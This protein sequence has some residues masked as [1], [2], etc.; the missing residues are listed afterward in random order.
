[1]RPTLLTLAITA[2]TAMPAMAADA[3]DL[4][5]YRSDDA[6]L[7]TS[8][9]YGPSGA[10]YALVHERRRVRLAGGAETLD[11][12]ALPA[13]LDTEAL[14]VR[15][16]SGNVLSRRL[17]L[18]GNAGI[19]DSRIGD[20]VKVLGASGTVL[21]EGTLRAT[22]NG[23]LI[24][25]G[26]GVTLVRDYAAVQ[27]ADANT[28]GGARLQVAV[29]GARAGE[30]DV[31]LDYATGGIG[32][33]AA[34][35]ATLDGGKSCR[36]DFRSLAS[37]ANRSGRD[38][39]ADT[40]KLVAG[41]PDFA[42]NS[43]PQPMMYAVRAE[44]AAAPADLP[45]QAALDDYRSYTIRGAVDLPGASVTQVPLYEPRTLDCT[46]TWLYETGSAWTPPRPMLTRDFNRGGAR[47]ASRLA[48]KAFDSLPAG[49]LRVLGIADDNAELL[50]EAR[51][52]DTPKGRTVDVELGTPF[53]L[54]AEREQTGFSVDKAARTLD[55]GFRI[56]LDNAGDTA[57]TVTVR[58]HPAR[59][60]EWTLLS[61]S[62]KPATQGVDTLEFA[63]NVP[64]HGNATLEYALR[65]QWTPGDEG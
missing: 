18:P 30:Q 22:G 49:Y 46:R 27:L 51:I 31:R 6:S 37:I 8:N 65:Y 3:I 52:A 13:T 15:L 34:Y 21:A 62:S 2:A 53:D 7:F 25:T 38:W 1:M 54:R 33:R 41:Q 40:L 39:H 45:Q 12:D 19:L 42:K 9:D 43:G 64:A 50:G 58:E 47:I 26:A 4:T 61:S 24:D 57:R 35:T 11:L 55:E 44:S 63:V 17:L 28:R 59:W 23:L 48:F 5:V 56:T 20:R 60:R 10:G 14:D 32:W 29:D 36:A 16:A